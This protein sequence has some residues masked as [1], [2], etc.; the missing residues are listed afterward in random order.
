MTTEIQIDSVQF[1]VNG[2]PTYRGRIHQG[3]K[4]EG[5]LFNSRMV[6]AI[7]DDQNPATADRWRYPDTNV[8]NPDRNTD[9]FC[10]MLPEYRRHG[11]LG[12]TVGLQGGGSV[13]LPEVYD[14]YINSAFDPDGALKPA[15]SDRLL[16]VLKAADAAGLVVIINY[17]YWKQVEK[18]HGEPAIVRATHEATEWLLQTGYGN[19]L[20]DVYNEFGD[21]DKITQSARIHELIGA[22]QEITLNGRRLLVSASTLPPAPLRSGPWEE[23][24]DFYLPHGND[25]WARQLRSN[26]RQI[27]ATPAFQANPRPLLI[28]EDSMYVNNLDA[29]VDEYASWGFYIQGYGAGGWDHGRYEWTQHG[30][31]STFGALTGYQTV[32]VNWSINTG[33]KRAFFNRLADITGSPG[34]EQPS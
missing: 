3:R 18:M 11:L 26:L 4:I 12:V 19:I 24:V 15:Y 31:E 8:W 17:F 13:Y 2:E 16:R 9:E 23:I 5:L 1:L 7:F 32:P 25:A 10:A 21:G 14:H 6:Q 27:K 28:N 33:L 30:R 29:A 34:A 22:A 20:V